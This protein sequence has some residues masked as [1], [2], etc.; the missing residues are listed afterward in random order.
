MQ[1]AI[2]QALLNEWD[3]IGV[4]E[5]PGADDE[6]TGFVPGICK[7]LLQTK[8]K[9]EIFDYLWRIE[10]EH[11]GLTG[12]REVTLAFADRLLSLASVK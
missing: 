4:K 7:M 10:T 2:K 9:E 5:I 8:T 3:P 1:A 11:M 6:Y 12:N